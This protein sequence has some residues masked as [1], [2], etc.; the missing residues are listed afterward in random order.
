MDL[1]PLRF[2]TQI[3]YYHYSLNSHII[4]VTWIFR[5]VYAYFFLF[6]YVVRSR[7]SPRSRGI[8]CILQ[9]KQNFAEI[10]IFSYKSYGFCKL[11]IQWFTASRTFLL[12]Y[13]VTK[14][15]KIDHELTT[16]SVN[17]VVDSVTFPYE[18][19]YTKHPWNIEC[20]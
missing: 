6:L 15:Q 5:C 2:K 10:H 1:K 11:I 14:T 13:D 3:C 8:V 7:N 20:L 12:I 19:C 17:L 16:P 18:F 9:E 4:Y